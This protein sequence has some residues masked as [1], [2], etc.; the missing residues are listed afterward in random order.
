MT[1]LKVERLQA[2]IRRTLATLIAQ[3]L[4]DPRLRMTT[5]TGV[6]LSADLS[7]AIVYVSCIGNENQQKTL[8]KGLESARGHLRSNLA[9]TLR[10]RTTPDLKFIYDDGIERSIELGEIINKAVAE[11]HEAQRARGE[12]T[13]DELP[14]ESLESTT[15]QPQEATNDC[16]E[17]CE[18]PLDAG[19]V[20]P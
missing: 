13:E 9:R 15:E 12:L 6:K 5:I 8:L 16:A 10:T 11:D 19:D 2:K 7:K 14:S 17:S 20:A 1:S 3:E 18:A 4:R